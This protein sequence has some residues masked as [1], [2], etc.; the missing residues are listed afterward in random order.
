MPP[1]NRVVLGGMSEERQGLR[2][3]K[4]DGGWKQVSEG[5]WSLWKG[6]EKDGFRVGRK[7]RPMRVQEGRGGLRRE[8]SVFVPGIDKSTRLSTGDRAGP[9]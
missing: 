5:E 1:G 3:P 8:F 4:T 6:V 9:E 2:D 7:V